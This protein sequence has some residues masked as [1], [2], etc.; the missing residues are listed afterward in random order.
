MTMQDAQLETI[1]TPRI[2]SEAVTD[3]VVNSSSTTIQPFFVLIEDN[4][5]TE[6][7]HPEVH[8]VFSDDGQE[9][10]TAA[11]LNA[12]D[13]T[14]TSDHEV[15]EHRVVI[16]D[17]APD[18]RTVSKVASLSQDWQVA[19]TEVSQAPS[20][21]G[22]TDKSGKS[23]M[24]KLSGYSAHVA[25]DAVI[26]TASTLSELV[27]MLDQELHSLEMLIGSHSD[28]GKDVQAAELDVQRPAYDE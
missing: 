27:A 26:S 19:T 3:E 17:L 16:V 1:T 18:M 7:M 24:L 13:D 28:E 9:L 20:W 15:E 4:S 11:T 21:H 6:I 2:Q 25:K 10:L 12:T 22:N 5:S 14:A 23:M 8:Y